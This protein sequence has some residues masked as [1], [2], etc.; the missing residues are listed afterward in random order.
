MAIAYCQRRGVI[1]ALQ[2]LRL[3][4]NSGKSTEPV[5]C[6]SAR[7]GDLDTTFFEN[8]SLLKKNGWKSLNKKGKKDPV[9]VA[10]EEGEKGDGEEKKS[11]GSINHHSPSLGELLFGFF[12]FYAY[13]FDHSKAC[14]TT[15]FVP[16][17][18]SENGGYGQLLSKRKRW[19]LKQKKWRISV[20]DPFEEWHDLG[21]VVNREGQLAIEAELQRAADLL[22]NGG[23]IA[24]LMV[25]AAKQNKMAYGRGRGRQ[26][27]GGTQGQEN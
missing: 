1:P 8:V 19:G 16:K 26:G 3:F 6:A 12:W 4:P 11:D 10:E 23:T 5:M 27:G 7:N 25:P 15:K 17:E 14:S 18:H 24:E 2:D 22:S 9:A 21:Q 20:E 13:E